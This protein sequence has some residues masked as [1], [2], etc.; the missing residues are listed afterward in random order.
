MEQN[1]VTVTCCL[2]YENERQLIIGYVSGLENIR[3]SHHII[4]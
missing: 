4:F 3:E 1:N 2:N